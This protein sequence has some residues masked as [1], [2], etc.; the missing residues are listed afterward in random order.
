MAKH[1]RISLQFPL[2]G[3]NRKGAYRQQPPYTTHDCLNVR[4][5]T[6]PECRERGG[7]RPGIISSHV[8]AIGDGGLVCLLSPMVISSSDGFT[9]WTDTFTGLSLSSDWAQASWSSAIPSILSTSIVGVTYAVAEAD[10]VASSLDIDTTESYVVEAYLLPWAGAWHGSYRIYLRMNDSSPDI[11]EDGVMVELTQTGTS[12]AY[13]GV[14]SSVVGGTAT[15]YNITPGTIGS[16]RPGWLSVTV[17]GNSLSVYWNDTLIATQTVDS[18][19]GK[20]VGFGLK[21][22]VDGGVSVTNVFRAQY[23]SSSYTSSLRSMLV[24]SSFGGIYYETFYGRVVE[25]DTDVGLR[26]DVQ[27]LAAQSGQDLYIADYGDLSASGTD[28]SVNGTALAATSITEWRFLGIDPAEDVVVVSNG[29]GTAVD[30]T[31]KI[32]AVNAASITLESSAG[33]G[34]CAYRIERAPK[35]FNTATKTMSIWTATTG[36][37]QVPT[38]CPIVWRYLD[39]LYLA[40]AEIAPHVWYC[41]RQGDPLDWDYSQTDSQRAI[42][43]PASEAGVPGDPITA[44]LSHSDDYSIIACLT[45]LWRMQGDPAYG[46]SLV[47]LSHTVGIVGRKAWCLGPSGELVFLSKNGLYALAAGANTY[48]VQLSLD[49]LPVELLNID[50]DSVVPSLEYDTYGRGVHVFLTPKTAGVRLHWWMDWERKTL[51]PDTYTSNHEPYAT[52]AV[53]SSITG[54]HGVIMGGRDGVLRRFCD[55]AEND[56]GTSFTSYA[57]IG[58]VAL[59]KDASLGSIVSLDANIAED[60]GDVTWEVASAL[61]FE[62][63]C[64]ATAIDTGTWT[65][66]LNA[67]SRPAC[68]GQACTVK[69]TGQ[70][71]RRW[72]VEEISAVIR[73]AGPRR[74]A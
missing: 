16:V 74:I 67:T 4:A 38:G 34:N 58:P 3:L 5:V 2:A 73:E 1:R 36:K 44:G 45:S 57:V 30:G 19:D 70:A 62:G 11:D 63:A 51:W 41:P 68:R 64:N 54:E 6:G 22:T 21:C 7:S 10:V 18:H 23:Y 53:Q 66:G 55:N 15:D 26:D 12:G 31:Y 48:P 17:T 9:A 33:V 20:R 29:T 35:I 71:K 49:V 27:L 47:N 14:I 28:G 40:G 37:G 69:L 24:A 32:S 8:D 43:G 60:S 72:A 25:A 50:T 46:G 61:T 59:A 56:C 39:R 65:A 42:A 52:C 13:T